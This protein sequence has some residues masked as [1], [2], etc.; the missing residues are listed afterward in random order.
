MKY[1]QLKNKILNLE[2]LSA[3]VET[4]TSDI[5]T[6]QT[7]TE[8]LRT[9]VDANT[10]AVATKL[11]KTTD[12]ANVGKSIIVDENGNL[13]F[14]KVAVIYSTVP[15][16]TILPYAGDIPPNGYLF[17]HGTSH[18]V[19]K[20]PDLYDVIGN[21]YGGDGIHFNVP[22]YRETVLVGAGENTTDTIANH[23]VYEL[24]EFK[25]DQVQ[26]HWHGLGN[27]NGT[28][29]VALG[30]SEKGGSVAGATAANEIRYVVN[31]ALDAVS[32]GTNGTPRTGTTTHGK[33]KGV[34]W[35]IKA[36]YT[37]EGQDTG[38]S[39][40][41]IDYVED[42]LKIDSNTN[43]TAIVY[44]NT[45]MS[46]ATDESNFY[47]VRNGICYVYMD[48]TMNVDDPDGSGI[49]LE[50]LP[51]PIGAINCQAMLYNNSTAPQGMLILNADGYII[52]EYNLKS[53]ERYL[54][55]F[56]YPIA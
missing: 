33:Q 48:F 44:D 28:S 24:G 19:E 9:D 56:S 25:D 27:E 38:V 12:V 37:N 2:T 18:L 8:G 23:D 4:N 17:C 14:S 13:T 11:N 54:C 16:G 42:E 47:I 5:E 51:N 10:T 3:Q 32:D 43:K 36:K 7:T 55:N 35:M 34:N 1:I 46:S 21:K 15:V 20:Y 52:A 53:S 39:D 6:L 22:D 45:Y 31:R 26:G 50:K 49:L 30:A 29:T 41:V 40:A